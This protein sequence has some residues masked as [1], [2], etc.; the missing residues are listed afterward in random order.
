MESERGELVKAESDF[1]GNTL[2]VR[3]LVRAMGKSEAYRK[4]FFARAGSYRFVELNMKVRCY[5]CV[6]LK[7]E[8][9]E[10]NFAAFSGTRAKQSRGNFIPCAEAN[11]RRIRRGNRFIFGQRRIRDEI[12]RVDCTSFCF[13]R[14]IHA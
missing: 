2:S 9:N 3:E 13:R 5:R 10:N 12:R 11:E 8:S 1:K 14:L 7:M 4:R 6:K